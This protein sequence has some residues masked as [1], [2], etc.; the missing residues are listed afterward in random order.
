MKLPGTRLA[1]DLK[2]QLRP[3]YLVAG[4]EPLLVQEAC[5]AIR[6]AAQQ[7]GYAERELHV[8]ERGFDWGGLGNDAANLSHQSNQ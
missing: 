6:A 4:D 1:A 3:V 5:G 7:A 8:V 2:S